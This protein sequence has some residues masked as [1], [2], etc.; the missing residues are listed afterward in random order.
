MLNFDHTE[1]NSCPSELDL[2]AAALI[3]TFKDGGKLLLCGNG[4]SSADCDHIAAEL[5]KG[6]LSRRPLPEPAR[7]R[8][9]ELYGEHGL[10]M[11]NCLQGALPA[12]SLSSNSALLT[13]IGNDISGHYIFAQQVYGYG[14]A[15]DSLLAISTSG[16]SI[17]VLMALQ[18]ARALEITTIG[19]TGSRP[20]TMDSY[21]DILVR[22][23][24]EAT[25]DVQECHI[26]MYHTLCEHVE[27]AIFG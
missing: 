5:M 6:F 16:E 2:A 24:H 14:R 23:P 25:R 10:N 4:G 18:V 3:R 1:P 26:K 7:K 12:I 19:F 21:C 17:N 9:S 22:A 20:S 8:M 27:R 11:A 13:A 15:N